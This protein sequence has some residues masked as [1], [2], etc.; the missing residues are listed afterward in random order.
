MRQ[1]WVINHNMSNSSCRHAILLPVEWHVRLA[2]DHPFRISLKTLYDAFLAPLGPT[3]AQLYANVFTW[4]RHATTHAASAAAQPH[5]G[6]Q[7]STTQLL[8]PKLHGAHDSWVQEQVNKIFPPLKAMTL[9]LSSTAF[10]TGMEQLCSD[11]AAQHA[12]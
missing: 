7:A 4:W 10:Q 12:T 8:P 11:L 9:P 6:L 2:W 3:K 1:L 5:S